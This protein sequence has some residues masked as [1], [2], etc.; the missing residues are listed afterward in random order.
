MDLCVE[1]V[2]IICQSVFLPF[3]CSAELKVEERKKMKQS[4]ESNQKSPDP[5]HTGLR[6]TRTRPQQGWCEVMRGDVLQ[7]APGL[8]SCTWYMRMMIWF[9]ELACPDVSTP[10]DKDYLPNLYCK[11]KSAPQPKLQRIFVFAG[12]CPSERVKKITDC[13]FNQ[14]YR[15]S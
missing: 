13:F 14:T 3:N 15:N 12:K 1:S 9:W 2:S 11:I 6:K 7:L 5:V 4:V 8:M 10:V